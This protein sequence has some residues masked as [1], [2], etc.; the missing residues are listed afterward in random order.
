VTTKILRNISILLI[1]LLFTP[2]VVNAAWEKVTPYN[3]Y[4]TNVETTP[5][6]LLVGEF[7]TRIWL[8]PPPLNDVYISKDLGQ[9]WIPLGLTGRGVK[10]IKFFKGKIYAV[11]YYVMENKVGL[12]VSENLGKTWKQIGPMF[13]PTKVNRDSQTIYLGGENH[14]LWISRDEGVTWIQKLGTGQ[15]GPYIKAIESSENITFVTTID[16]TYKTLDNGSLWEEVVFLNNKGIEHFCIEGNLIF[17]GSSGTAGLYKS[18]NL[19]VTW[20]KIQSFGNYAVGD[21]VFYNNQLYAGRVNPF[22]SNIYTVYKSNDLGTS[23]E[24]TVLNVPSM[25][26]VIDMAWIFSEPSYLYAI[27]VNNGIHKFTIPKQSPEK[28]EFLGIPWRNGSSNELIDKITAFFDHE[29]PLLGYGYFKEPKET[30][31]TTLNFYGDRGNEPK[32]YYS[33]HNGTDYALNYGSEIIAPADG[34]AFYYSCPDCGNSI[35]INHLNGYQTIYMHLQ[36]TGLITLGSNVSVSSGVFIGKVGMT[37]KTNGPHLHFEVL[38]NGLYPNGLV[39]PYGWLDLKSSDPWPLFSWQDFLGQHNGTRSVYLWKNE[40]SNLS[41]LIIGSGNLTLDNKTVSWDH[42]PTFSQTVSLKNY[43]QPTIPSSQSNLAYVPN[44][45][46]LVDAYDF[47]GGKILSFSETAKIIINFSGSD[48]SKIVKET[49]KIYFWNGVTGLWE[50]IPTVLDLISNTATGETYHFSNFVLLGEKA[51]SSPPVTQII[52]SGS[53]NANWF[54]EFPTVE[55]SAV[56][57]ESSQTTIFFT[58]EGETGWEEYLSPFSVNKEGIINIQF[59]SMDEKGN[60]EETQNY[61]IQIDTQNKGKK[62][63]RVKNAGFITIW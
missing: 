26:W 24:D 31:T 9:S 18:I 33:S 22:L 3:N 54:T 34:T 42:S 30:N 53:K 46:I 39:D 15:F 50:Y 21:L 59:R 63:V 57:P 7:D 49:V 61:V 32:L 5:W 58:L 8:T 47:L 19:G 25:K 12:F 45:S 4:L 17:A 28:L 29:Y 41:G 55:L 37:G 60:I 11:T 36:K 38:Q 13:S 62:I 51:D 52:V 40:P 1:Y 35:K 20:E 23:W 6:G 16:K 27:S 43:F 10:D 56:D 14:G 2:F 48:L 44:S